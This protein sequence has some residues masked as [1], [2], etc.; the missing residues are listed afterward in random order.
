MGSGIQRHGIS[1]RTTSGAKKRRRKNR[2]KTKQRQQR[3]REKKKA[4]QN[5]ECQA[6]IN[7]FT[8]GCMAHVSY[9]SFRVHCATRTYYLPV[10]LVVV[11]FRCADRSDCVLSMENVFRNFRPSTMPPFF[12]CFVCVPAC[13][14]SSLKTLW[15]FVFE[16]FG[17]YALRPFFIRRS[18]YCS[19]GLPMALENV[20]R[21]VCV[22]VASIRREHFSPIQNAFR[23]F[24]LAAG[25]VECAPEC[26]ALVSHSDCGPSC[27]IGHDCKCTVLD[28]HADDNDNDDD[29]DDRYRRIRSLTKKSTNKLLLF[30]CVFS[31]FDF[32]YTRARAPQPNGQGHMYL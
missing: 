16:F 15:I 19:F 28:C 2:R 7:G 11:F 13:E 9:T 21:K 26:M 6:T 3:N 27:R 29:Y 4:T 14:C 23:P 32:W 30:C 12:F 1:T 31:M 8:F 24:K 10:F 25:P 5:K 22:C 20:T 18:I 17:S